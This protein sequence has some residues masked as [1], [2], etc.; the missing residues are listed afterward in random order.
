MTPALITISPG[1]CPHY[2]SNSWPSTLCHCPSGESPTTTSARGKPGKPPLAA[3]MSESDDN[4]SLRRTAQPTSLLQL[5]DVIDL[6]SGQCPLS[7]ERAPTVRRVSSLKDLATITHISFEPS[8]L[9]Q[10]QYRHARW[11]V[12]LIPSLTSALATL[13]CGRRCRTCANLWGRSTCT[14]VCRH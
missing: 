2:P 3:S 9:H 13:R 5:N 11:G 6:P 7:P 10:L 14:W 1:P 12:V 8:R 4:Q